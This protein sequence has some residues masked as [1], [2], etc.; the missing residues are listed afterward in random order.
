MFISRVLV[1]VLVF[2][3]YGLS[4]SDIDKRQWK[5]LNNDGLHDPASPA[6]GVLQEPAEALRPLPGDYA[7]NQVLWVKAL[8]EGYI[9]PRSN[10]FPDTTVEFLD[11]DIIME[12]TSIMPMVLFPHAQHTEWL[13]CK[14]CHDI[15]FKEKVGA[16]PIN[17]FQILQGEYCG[18]CHGAVAF[19]LTE[20]LRCHSVPR[21]TFKGEYGVQP[22]KT[23]AQRP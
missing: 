6:I 3:A 18:R 21:H 4:H 1:F 17:M 9:E 20:C 2:G 14:N 23:E 22:K 11:M 13:D 16:N 7:G 10:I 5:P 15:I 19:P 12:N 8:R